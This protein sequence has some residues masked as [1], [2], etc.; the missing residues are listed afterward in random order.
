VK[1][2]ERTPQRTA[3]DA[4]WIASGTL[5]L[6]RFDPFLN[7]ISGPSYY[8]PDET[9][10]W[11]GIRDSDLA[12][13]FDLKISNFNRYLLEGLSITCLPGTS[14]V[15]ASEILDRK[16][17]PTFEPTKK[18]ELFTDEIFNADTVA[19][20]VMRHAG[21]WSRTPTCNSIPDLLFEQAHRPE[22]RV[23]EVKSPQRPTSIAFTMFDEIREWL[24]LTTDETARLV[25][26]GRTTPLA[27][28]R[29][30]REP[31]PASARRLYQVHSIVS[32]L[33]MR[34]GEP[35]AV[36][37]LERGDPSPR[38]RLEQG[39]ITSVAR[40]VERILLQREPR[41]ELPARD[42]LVV[43][44]ED[45]PVARVVRLPRGRRRRSTRRGDAA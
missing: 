19:V 34:V 12:D 25:G 37:W 39:E 24:S 5:G 40:E 43:E 21:P 30:G 45:A 26:V 2:K 32:A 27:W 16:L 7:L 6:N 23:V 36:E 41:S 18:D 8:D 11:S 38:H 20:Y 22:L 44:D 9:G 14:F 42:E 13:T 3:S 33:V 1:T 35:A 10:G 4:A 28:E 15:L 17:T 29:E 31:R